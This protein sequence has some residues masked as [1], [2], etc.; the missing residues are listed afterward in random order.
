MTQY[1]TM[2]MREGKEGI[3]SHELVADFIKSTS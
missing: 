3:D 1:Y 2:K